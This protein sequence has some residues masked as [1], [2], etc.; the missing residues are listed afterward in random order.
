MKSRTSSSKLTLLRKD[1]FRFAPLWGIYLA[2]CLIATLQTLQEWDGSGYKAMILSRMIP[3]FAL[4]NMVYAG[5]VALLVFGNLFSAKRCHTFLAMPLRREKWFLNQVLYGFLCSTLPNLIVSL[6][7]MPVLEEYWYVSLVWGLG[8]TLQYLFFFGL[9]VFCVFLS[10]NQIG[11]IIFYGVLNY[12]A[13]M[14]QWLIDGIYKPLLYGMII[15]TDFFAPFCPVINIKS[16]QDLFYVEGFWCL[17]KNVHVSCPPVTICDYTGFTDNWGYLVA[18]AVLGLIFLVPALHLYRK[19][20]LECAGDLVAIRG[21]A[22]VLAALFPIGLGCGIAM[23]TR[24]FFSRRQIYVR[25]EILL[26]IFAACIV[27]GWFGGQMLLQRTVKIFNKKLFMKFAVFAAAL[28]ATIGLTALD[29]VGITRYIPDAERVQQVEITPYSAVPLG[30]STSTYYIVSTDMEMIK[31]IQSAHRQILKDG[32]DD[33]K[34]GRV[35]TI[36]YTL[37]SGKQVVREYDVARDTQAW[38]CVV[39]ILNTPERV[40]RNYTDWE[41]WRRSVSEITLNEHS[42]GEF[43]RM[44]RAHT[45]QDWPVSIEQMEEELLRALVADLEEGHVVDG[46]LRNQ[47]DPHY[48]IRLNYSGGKGYWS[49]LVHIGKDA[50]HCY[51]WME[52]YRELMELVEWRLFY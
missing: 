44:Y 9:A 7:L 18:C 3:K 52:K 49:D 22:P 47:E 16:I 36:R 6:C 25:T 46:A 12:A 32:K 43:H 26:V 40:L 21:L 15:S 1:I 19:R 51:A 2:G 11:M 50:R 30:N 17:V 48:Y 14:I 10:G 34:S 20:K 38:E 39:A 35:I 37:S 28:C 24:Y 27:L 41:S 33:S 45:G 13:V 5:L 31:S 23:L 29:P 8:M 42:V 4:A